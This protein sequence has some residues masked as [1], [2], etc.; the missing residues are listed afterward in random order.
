MIIIDNATVEATEGQVISAVL[1]IVQQLHLRIYDD[2]VDSL[3]LTVTLL[4]ISVP[5]PCCSGLG[6][7][8]VNPALTSQGKYTKH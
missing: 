7:V 5:T 6:G 2:N 8:T 3:L 4:L 1:Q